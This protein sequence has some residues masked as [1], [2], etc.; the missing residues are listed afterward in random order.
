M[1][2]LDLI[3]DY[4]LSF[5]AVPSAVLAV[6]VLIMKL[7]KEVPFVRTTETQQLEAARLLRSTDGSGASEGLHPYEKGLLYRILAKSRYVSIREMDLLIRLPDPYQH[8]DRLAET[9]RLFDR[10]EAQDETV[11]RFVRRYRRRWRR[12]TA[13]GVVTVA[14]FLFAILAL[15]PLLAVAVYHGLYVPD[16][17][18]MNEFSTIAGD[19]FTL[20]AVSLPV[21]GYLALSC[22]WWLGRMR[23]AENLIKAQAGFAD[24]NR[25]KGQ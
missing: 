15:L 11:F 17:V 4:G 22:T 1:E 10:K 5:V 23:R 9:K 3:V 21:F 25:V 2:Y 20:L 7:R 24:E 18:T 6:A 13:K 16:V 8:I 19:L 14:Y 12:G